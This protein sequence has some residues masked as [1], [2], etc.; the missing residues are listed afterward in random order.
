MDWPRYPLAKIA[1]ACQS[2]MKLGAEDRVWQ[3]GLEH[4][5]A[6]MRELLQE[7]ERQSRALASRGRMGGNE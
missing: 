4:I 1:P 7:M 5:E 3:L 2:D 6:H